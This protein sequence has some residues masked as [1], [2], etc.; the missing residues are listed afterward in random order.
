MAFPSAHA[1]HTLADW[2]LSALVTV[3]LLEIT[4]L[5]PLAEL[6]AVDRHVTGAAFVLALLIAVA[7][8]S[9]RNWLVRC[10][11]AVSAGAVAVRVANLFLP[12]ESLRVW[13][14]CLTMTSAALL[15]ALVLWQV[16]T[17]GRVNVHRLLGAIAAYLL[18]GMGF[19]QAYRL[20]VLWAPPALLVQGAPMTYDALVPR[21]EYYSFVTLT[22][23]GFGDIVPLHP[24]ARAA[25]IFESLI[26]VL[27]P[28]VLLGYLVSLETGAPR[29][30][31]NP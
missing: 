6:G 9:W 5:S 2:G 13:D 7:A 24:A 30:E 25:T 23:L 1:R 21:L 8:L 10:F 27:Y 31:R 11:L 20:I 28:A 26:G 4:V 12:D 29:D 22:S 3:L 15:A 17:P 18:I 19:A 16:F 14:G